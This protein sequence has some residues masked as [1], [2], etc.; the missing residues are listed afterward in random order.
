MLSCVGGQLWKGPSVEYSTLQASDAVPSLRM[1][2]VNA[3]PL[4][5]HGPNRQGR[6]THSYPTFVARAVLFVSSV[7]G[8]GDEKAS[9]W[10]FYMLQQ[11]Q[12]LWQI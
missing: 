1:K 5:E 10:L 7:V 2:K 12:L 11:Q 3:K 8:E 4:R 9:L 6:L